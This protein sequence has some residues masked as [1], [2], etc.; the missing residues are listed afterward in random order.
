MANTR[1]KW[2][3]WSGAVALV[4]LSSLTSASLE[5]GVLVS[6]S[7]QSGPWHWVDGGLNTN[8]QYDTGVPWQ[9][10]APAVIEA[11]YAEGISF[12]PGDALALSYVSGIWS[13]SG[14]LGDAG[15]CDASGTLL[16]GPA[17][18]PGTDGTGLDRGSSGY[19]TWFPGHYCAVN[20]FPLNAMTMIGVFTDADG[21]IIGTPLAIGN[22]RTVIIPTGATR[23]QLGAEDVNFADNSGAITMAITETPE[24]STLALLVAT[25]CGFAGWVWRRR[26]RGIKVTSAAAIILI[27]ASVA[28]ADVFN[29]GGTRNADGT[30]NGLASLEFVSVGNPGNAGELSGA[31]TG[32]FGPDRICGAVAYTYNIGKYEVTNGQYC[33]FLNAKLPNIS[34]PHPSNP[35]PAERLPSDTYGLYYPW[36]E[37]SELGGINYD[38]LGPVGGKFSV[39]AGFEQFPVNHVSWYDTIRFANWLTNGQGSGDTETGSYNISGGGQ[40]SGTVAVPDA[41]TRI[42]WSQGSTSYY[43]LSSEDEW[44]KAAYHKNDG[45]TDHYWDYPTGTDATPSNDLLTPDPGNNANFRDTDPYDYGYTTPTRLTNVGA[46]ANSPSAYGTFDQGG[47]VF[48]W[49]EASIYT[50]Y[51]GRG[52]HGGFYGNGSDYM[53]ASYRWYDDDTDENPNIGF[54]VVRIGEPVPEPGSIA[55]LLA[56]SLG[57]VGV[58][59]HRPRRRAKG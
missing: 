17:T 51:L 38:P 58:A 32:G 54:R 6:V 13:G 55:L 50:T 12:T 7:A 15:A 29:M 34:D 10:Q 57:L 44:Y 27:A 9:E 1:T 43:L 59:L 48:E 23:L 31:G 21:S 11:N 2:G 16:N 20:D 30:W 24:P 28:H 36:M 25:S 35:Q 37:K 40:N 46:F 52:Q 4:A 14:G 56:A 3:C 8:F 22:S 41:A 42:V 39:K 19:F 49:N 45:I 5:A 33:E 26:I 53:L 18:S 47:N